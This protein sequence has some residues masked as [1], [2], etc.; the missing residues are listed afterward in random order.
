MVRVERY[1]GIVIPAGVSGAFAF[2][3]RALSLF[4][5]EAKVQR[6]CETFA[7]I[8]PVNSCFAMALW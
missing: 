5:C 4:F 6:I 8:Q 7:S 2:G 1:G 3:T